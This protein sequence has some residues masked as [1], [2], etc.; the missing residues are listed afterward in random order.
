GQIIGESLDA[1]GVRGDA[2]RRRVL[3]LLDEVRLGAGW[4]V[5]TSP[6]EG[7]AKNCSRDKHPEHALRY[8]IASEFLTVTKGL[9]DSWEDDA[10]V[11]DK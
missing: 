8:R 6:L 2:R 11:R 9:W 5:V 4:N 10:F 1:I 3:Q 7:S